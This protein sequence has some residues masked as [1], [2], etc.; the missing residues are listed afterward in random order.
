MTILSLTLESAYLG[1]LVFILRQ[2]PGFEMVGDSGMG[3]ELVE[4]QVAVSMQ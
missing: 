2:G 4:V 1:K 3:M